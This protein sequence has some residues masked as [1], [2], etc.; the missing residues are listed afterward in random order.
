MEG[1]VGI[2]TGQVV[3]QLVMSWFLYG[4]C[5]HPAMHLFIYLKLLYLSKEKKRESCVCN[6]LFE[7]NMTIKLQ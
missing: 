4:S 5:T 3:E 1:Q 6:Q 2:I 7:S